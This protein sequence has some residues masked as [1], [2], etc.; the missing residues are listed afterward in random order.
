MD[1][2]NI[3]RKKV[4]VNICFKWEKFYKSCSINGA[5]MKFVYAYVVYFLGNCQ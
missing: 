2:E 5:L 3:E 1:L 4:E